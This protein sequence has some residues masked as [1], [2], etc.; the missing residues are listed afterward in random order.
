LRDVGRV[1]D[2]V[3]G[4]TGF[5]GP[6]LVRALLDQGR[7]VRCIVRDRTRA[8]EL[9]GL[10]V[11]VQEG[12][13]RDAS[14]VARA[15]AGVERI[16]HL[17]GGGKVSTT[18][19]EGLA[20]LRDANVGTLKAVL[21]AARG[22][23]VQRV[24]VFSSISAMGVQLGID[25]D[26]DS[27]CQPKTPHEI[28]KYESEQIARDA[29]TRDG[30]PVVILRPSQIY[31][32]GDVRSEILVLVRLARFGLIPLFGG[33]EGSVPWVFISDVVEATLCAA[34]R[35]AA[36]GR[37]YIVSDTESYRFAEVTGAIARALGRRRGGIIIPRAIAEPAVTALECA[38]VAFGRDPPFTRHRLASLMGRRSVDIGRARRELDYAP[39][40]GLLDGMERTVRWYTDHGVR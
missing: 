29:W 8:Q 37:T 25:L 13:L 27:P 36:I 24:V 7:G 39:R 17:A 16:F 22:A 38:A 35:P 1:T 10:G 33:G 31:G 12:D 14:A 32:P 30:L 9:A 20:A 23:G 21:S 4:A 18:S 5:V 40:V 2:L 15:V 3:T 19:V 11:D 6:H 26:E 28:A 34:E